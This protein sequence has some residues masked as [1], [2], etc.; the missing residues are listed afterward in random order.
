MT[1]PIYPT[2]ATRNTVPHP[3]AI[4]GLVP[5]VIPEQYRRSAKGLA[6]SYA[7]FTRDCELRD[8][9]G[10]ATWGRMLLEDQ[11]AS[12]VVLIDPALIRTT[13]ES[14]ERTRTAR[15]QALAA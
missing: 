14:F 3:A 10:V 12:G 2:I 13:V 1:K 6:L 15:R 11:E 7:G 4:L 8:V 9:D 5:N